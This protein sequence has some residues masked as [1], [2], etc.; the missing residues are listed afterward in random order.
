MT[1]SSL[2]PDYL[3]RVYAGVLGKLIGVYLGRPFEGWTY[4]RIMEELGPIEYY[5][6]DRLGVPLVVTDDDV[7]GTFGF[8]RALAEHGVSPDLSAED[9]G[10]TWLNATI[11]QRSI[12]WWGGNGNST[13]HTAWL[14]LKRGIPAP[15]SGSIELNGEA[16][17]EQIGAQIFIDGW[18]MVAPG[19]PALAAKLA[20]AAGSVSHD[21]ES[22]YAAKLVAAME[23]EAF[24]SSDIDH[25]I[26]VGLNYV[27]GNS[28]IARLIADIRGWHARNPDWRD[29]RALIEERYGYDKFPG[30]CHVVPN[31]A[32]IILALLYAPLDFQRAMTIVNTAGWDTD[33]NSGNVGCLLGIMLGL[34]GLEAGPDWRGPLADRTLISTADGGYA[35]NDAARVAYDLVDLGRQLAGEAPLTPPKDGAQFHFTLPGSVQ[36]FTAQPGS[37]QRDLLTVA[38]EEY[39][40]AGTLAMRFHGLAPG[41]IAS[42]STPTFAPP[43]VVQMRTYDL[44]ATPLVY[45][46]QTIAARVLADAD[47]VGSLKVRLRLTVYGRDDVLVTRDGPEVE[48][49][50]GS[51]TT[52]RWTVPDLDG[53][54]VQAIGL[55]LSAA[56]ARAEGVLRLHHL[57]WDG[58]PSVSLHRPKDPS[59]FWR[60]AW[61]NGVSFFSKNFPAAFRLAQDRGEGIIIHGTR[62]WTDLAVSS[63]L[64]VHLGATAG[65]AARVQ[66]LRRYY[67]LVLESGDRIRLIRARDDQRTVLAEAVCRWSLEQAK[68]LELQVVG[69]RLIGLV[70][71]VKTL[72][73]DDTDPRASAS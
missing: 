61:V 68:H 48:V 39:A 50:A 38:Q 71:G 2:P 55:A 63:R 3:H 70:D 37:A 32:L 21:G 45:P 33:C 30:N 43:E 51:D 5:V 24:V 1:A 9:I 10:K 69:T 42:V 64:L 19:N 22:V 8:V 58:T 7:S 13:E 6:H 67:G 28:L 52:L 14:N 35:I 36:G 11:E 12:L 54:P 41:R 27:P 23:A 15:R 25:L 34:A 59:D 47:N 18:A 57:R 44:Q 73:V 53:Q 20:E 66:G 31:H 16:V 40:G 65:L 62:Q 49:A 17:A 4:Q 26:D 29:T 60:R 46:G 72:E 56:G